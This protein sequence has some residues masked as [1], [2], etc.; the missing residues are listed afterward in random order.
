MQVGN[1]FSGNTDKLYLLS[2]Q[3]ASSVVVAKI[4][5]VLF[6]IMVQNVFCINSSQSGSEDKSSHGLYLAFQPQL[7]PWFLQNPHLSMHNV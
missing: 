4:S 7:K 3:I 6:L 1:S 2:V 5:V